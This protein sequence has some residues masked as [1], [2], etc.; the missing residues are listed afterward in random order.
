VRSV[1]R[2]M[3]AQLLCAASAPPDVMSLR[4]AWSLFSFCRVGHLPKR[5]KADSAAES[6]KSFGSTR[7]IELYLRLK[8]AASLPTAAEVKIIHPLV[9]CEHGAIC[10]RATMMEVD[11]W[12]Y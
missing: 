6:G 2:E 4:V 12:F 11:Q 9:N 5:D 7:S 8:A 3:A 10:R 1:L